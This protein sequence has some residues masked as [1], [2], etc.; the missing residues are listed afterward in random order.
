MAIAY[1]VC[2]QVQKP[3]KIKYKFHQFLFAMISCHWLYQK[4]YMM[5]YYCHQCHSQKSL[6]F[7]IEEIIS[8]VRIM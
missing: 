4:N 2:L 3:S 8:I 5:N 1:Q 6:N 7:C